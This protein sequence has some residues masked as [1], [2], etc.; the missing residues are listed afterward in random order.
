MN[1]INSSY[2]I[3]KQS[4]NED[5]LRFIERVGR[6]CYKSEDKITK[7]SA[8][9]FVKSLVNNKHYAMIEHFRFIAVIPEDLYDLIHSINPKYIEMTKESE[10]VVSY[11]SRALIDL[12]DEGDLLSEQE[13]AI[14]FLAIAT[15][16]KYNIPE[17]FNNVTKEKVLDNS[18]EWTINFYSSDEY[19]N[20]TDNIKELEAHCWASV[21]IIC[22]RGIT[23][24]LVRMRP[25]SFG[26]EST[27]YVNYNNKGMS[28]I[29][30]DKAMEIDSKMCNLDKSVKK[31]IVDEW[32]EAMR[33]AMQRYNNL[34]ALGATPQIAR[35]VLP[36]DI[37]SEIVM[38]ANFKEW[39]HI[40]ELRDDKAHVHPK[41]Y[42]IAQPL[43]AD[44]INDY[45][46][47][48]NE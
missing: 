30:I 25:C 31:L 3:V 33:N 28:F 12:L 6:T 11:S 47:V 43:H 20:H 45:G 19:Y 15:C 22:D 21:R 24:E 42:E 23:H 29:S 40:F 7:T 48:F 35:G 32:K 13:N 39:Q 44:F 36:T 14:L 4:K 18:K 17:I 41:M 46:K 38:T 8:K 5:V 10:P 2:E 34:L 37:K 16:N 26:Q 9:N 27:R 1:I